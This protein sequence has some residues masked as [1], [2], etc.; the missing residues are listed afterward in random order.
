MINIVSK[1]AQQKRTPE[2]VEAYQNAE[3]LKMRD[4]YKDTWDQRFEPTRRMIQAVE[5]K[6]PGLNQFLRANG[7]GDISMLV[8][9]LNNHA[10]VYWAKRNARQGK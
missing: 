2:Q 1:H 8:N 6:L 10:P 5:A 7:V 3:N 4:L 9:L